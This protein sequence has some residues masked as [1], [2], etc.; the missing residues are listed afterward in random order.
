MNEKLL[1][2]LKPKELLTEFLEDY[3]SLHKI[4]IEKSKELIKQAIFYYQKK[5]KNS[6]LC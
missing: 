3:N 1:L 2:E 6:A 5:N 4:N